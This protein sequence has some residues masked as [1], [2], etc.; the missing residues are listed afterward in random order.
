MI[1][2]KEKRKKIWHT[3]VDARIFRKRSTLGSMTLVKL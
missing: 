3:S 2:Q 1:H